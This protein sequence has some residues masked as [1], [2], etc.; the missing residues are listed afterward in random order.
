VKIGLDDY[1]QSGKNRDDFLALLENAEKIYPHPEVVISG[2]SVIKPAEKLGRALACRGEFHCF[3]SGESGPLGSSVVYLDGS[4]NLIQVTPELMVSEFERTAQLGREVIFKG[5][6]CFSK[7]KI[8]KQLTSEILACRDFKAALPPITAVSRCPMLVKCDNGLKVVNGYDPE[9][10]ILASGDPVPEIP[11]QE[12]AE[13]LLGLFNDTKFLSPGDK[14]RYFANTLSP[15]LILSGILPCR[16]PIAYNEADDS[17]TGKN[18]LHKCNAVIYNAPVYI[19]NTVDKGVGSIDEKF[20]AHL[21]SGHTFIS[22]DNLTSPKGGAPFDSEFLCSFMTEDYCS[23]RVPYRQPVTIDP[24]RHVVMATTNGCNLSRDLTNRCCPVRLCKREAGFQYK[25]Y[26]EGH[27]LDHIRA[28]QSYYLGCVFA[29][30]KEYHRL[31][32][33]RLEDISHDTS[34]TPWFQHMGY[35]VEK[36]LGLAPILEGLLEV[37]E[38]VASPN[39]NWLRDMAVAVK[40]GGLLG[41]P[42]TASELVE[43]ERNYYGH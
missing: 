7:A 13:R 18:Y 6:V 3:G 23:A 39:L 29:I 4:K 36:M 30:V 16:A 21:I 25:R 9:S 31:G 27:L 2:H 35:I 40:S 26:Q 11:F 43:I 8:S 10:G 32:T 34:F 19:C 37:R 33:P 5:E 28:W 17:Q 15:A 22:W 1:L 42:L 41:R 38:R 12:A 14:S 24:K 20:G